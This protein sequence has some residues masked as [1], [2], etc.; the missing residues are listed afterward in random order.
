MTALISII[1]PI[2]KVETYLSRCIDSILNQTYSDIEVIL[3]NDGSPDKCG[4]ICE[5]YAKKDNRIQV[6][7]KENGG[8]SDAQN[9]GIK[10]AKGEFITFVD[11]DDHIAPTMLEILLENMERHN[12][13]ISTC[14]FSRD[15]GFENADSLDN[16]EVV[17]SGI[18]AMEDLFVTNFHIQHETWGK[19]YK[20]WLFTDISFPKGYLSGDQYTTYKLLF[21]AQKV[22]CTKRKLYFYTRRNDSITGSIYNQQRLY[23]I[24]AGKQAIEFVREKAHSLENHVWCFYIGINI[25][26]I[27][28]MLKDRN[29]RKHR[30]SLKELRLTVL[31][32]L[33]KCGG[34]LRFLPK[35]RRISILL[36]RL[37]YWCYIPA[38]KLW[39]KG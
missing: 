21:Y 25:H 7:H 19:L 38:R 39:T 10:F 1:V 2:Y 8:Q 37:G 3:I 4:K 27:N 18:Q 13:D 6:I 15:C 36:L 9:A 30:Q 23:V 29:W 17:L 35:Q 32:G 16:N 33:K 11:G 5:D 31:S 20:T 26:Q 34:Q 12:A 14:L 28:E 22:V 24:E